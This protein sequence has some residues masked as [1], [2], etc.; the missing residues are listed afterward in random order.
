MPR[1]FKL[2]RMLLEDREDAERSLSPKSKGVS[3]LSDVRRLDVIHN[4]HTFGLRKETYVQVVLGA[5][6]RLGHH[7]INEDSFSRAFRNAACAK[8]QVILF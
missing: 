8:Q 2:T 6:Y 7:A 5:Y 3:E 1:A 4:N